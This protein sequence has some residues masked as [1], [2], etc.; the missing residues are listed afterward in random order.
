MGPAQS[1][2]GCQL[3]NR[4]SPF[5]ILQSTSDARRRVGSR[6][7]TSIFFVFGLLGLTSRCLPQS[8][9]RASPAAF[10][11][12]LPSSSLSRWTL[13]PPPPHLL[14]NTQGMVA[15]ASPLSHPLPSATARPLRPPSSLSPSLE[16]GH[17]R[18][19]QVHPER[20]D[21]RTSGRRSN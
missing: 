1:V 9:P 15:A 5:L 6:V 4:S 17:L 7:R 21:R 19:C 3:I 20:R 16:E 8:P 14:P 12:F 10:L 18:Q 2:K 11:Q 13:A